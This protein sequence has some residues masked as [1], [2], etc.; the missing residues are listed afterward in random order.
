MDGWLQVGVA[1]DV[2]GDGGGRWGE[3]GNNMR[4]GKWVG[5]YLEGYVGVLKMCVCLR[6]C[7][8]VCVRACVSS[9]VR[10]CV[11][12]LGVTFRFTS[13]VPHTH[14]LLVTFRFPS[15]LDLD[16]DLYIAGT[17]LVIV[18]MELGE[19]NANKTCI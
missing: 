15:L 12:V 11:C 1:G 14:S 8:R 13:L 17:I 9:C 5:L 16:L 4:K 19:R 2:G 3:G 7:V 10:A 18:A 6:A